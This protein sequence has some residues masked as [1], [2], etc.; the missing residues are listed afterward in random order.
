MSLF[1]QQVLQSRQQS[2]EGEVLLRPGPGA[3]L[4][5]LGLLLCLI[6]LLLLASKATYTRRETV[7][8]WLDVPGGALALY[9]PRPAR[10]LSVDAVEGQWVERGDVLASFTAETVLAGGDSAQEQLLLDL[11]AQREQALRQQWLM[12]KRYDS[13]HETLTEQL[14][15]TVSEQDAVQARVAAMAAQLELVESRAQR[16]RELHAKGHLGLEQVERREAEVLQHVHAVAELKQQS[17][18]VENRHHALTTTLRDLPQERAEAEASATLALLEINVDLTR[19]RAEQGFELRAPRNGQVS[20]LQ[21]YAGQWVASAVPLMSLLPP[22]NALAAQLLLPARAAGLVTAGQSLQLRYDAYP[23]QKFGTF[24]AR[25]SDIS[26]SVL[27][28]GEIPDAV[29]A[30]REAVYRAQ[31][32]LTTETSANAVRLKPGMTFQADIELESRS[33]LAWALEPLIGLWQRQK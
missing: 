33:L 10:A 20:N 21:V 30:P 25:M 22:D 9:A 2:L 12:R 27:R 6:L 7:R 32:Q 18:A 17:L 1:R 16:A 13:R 15:L 14:R 26:Q 5:C 4:L 11:E 24:A 3:S 29:I 8:G 23:Y 19:L 28:P 31:A